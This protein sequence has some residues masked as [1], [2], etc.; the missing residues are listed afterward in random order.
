MLM[1]GLTWR[2]AGLRYKAETGETP[3]GNEGPTETPPVEGDDFDKERAMETIRKL[4]QFEKDA[5][6]LQAEADAAKK[7]DNDRRVAELA[8]QQKFREL[9]ESER[10][11][12]ADYESQMAQMREAQR[13][14][15][16]QASIRQAAQAAGFTD[17]G[18]AVQFIAED[19]LQIDEDG[20][21][22]NAQQVIEKLA[23]SKPYL[24]AATRAAPGLQSGPRPTGRAEMPSDEEIRLFAAR[25]GVMPQYVK[26]TMRS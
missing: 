11:R 5:K 15:A 19:M 9:Y 14:A 2:D 26:Q 13:R 23:Q 6:R 24:L 3:G 1:H 21:V 12:A 22:T 7:A 10:Q 18:D 25:Y 17:P 20:A 16:I 8:E 4:R